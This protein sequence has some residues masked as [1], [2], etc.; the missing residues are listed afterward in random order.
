[1][2]Q[3]SN[4][5]KKFYKKPSNRIFLLVFIGYLFVCFYFTI[6]T[7]NHEC[8]LSEESALLRLEGI[9]NSLALQID[10]DMHQ[11]LVKKYAL[12]DEILYNT[13]DTNYYHIHHV[14]RRNYEAN[15]LKSPIYTMVFD[16]IKNHFEFIGTSSDF[17]YFRHIY[18]SY[19]SLL[20][21]KYTEGG[22]IPMYSDRFGMWLSAFAPV[23]DIRGNTVAV[24]MADLDFGKFLE[25]AKAIAFK[26]L[27]VSLFIILPF[28]LLLVF[29]LR[30]LI[31]REA[32]MKTRLE[33][34]YDINL[35]ISEQLEQSLDKLS[36]VD[37]LRKEMIAN[38]SHDLRTPLTNLSGYIETLFMRRHDITM[39]ER[40]RYL[41]IAIKESER[42]KKLIEDLFEL[43]K[44]ESNQIIVHSEPF[45]IAE[46]L[47]D[48]MAKYE[49]VCEEKGIKL[50]TNLSENTPWV[51]A[52]I[53][54]IDR[55]LQNL[56]DNAI[57]YNFNEEERANGVNSVVD[58]MVQNM[59]NQLFI[60]ISN[61]GKMI[62]EDI[63]PNVFDRYFRTLSMEGSTGL[64]LAIVKKI[65]ELHQSDITVKSENN[66]TTFEFFLPIY[67][68]K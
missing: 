7:Y 41:S 17:P 47:Q 65:I 58:L 46:L 19:N 68:K 2:F 10:G 20:K 34:A 27:M 22:V 66:L 13:Q 11:D 28:I 38:I 50:N 33:E 57:R 18:D 6:W 59:D 14:L 12:K 3:F 16:S 15:M 42:L 56:L 21:E 60:S 31:F 54:L 1:M 48:V 25:D 23:R 64:G 44:L 30:R 24:V 40:E 4:M 53:K 49:V 61:T 51:V 36:S 9:V 32:K 52:D 8:N 29:L 5:I 43:S 62:D 35:K 67:Q 63:L 39:N 37:R 55:V 45:P 26:N